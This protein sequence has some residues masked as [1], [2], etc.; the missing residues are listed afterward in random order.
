M[1]SIDFGN[2]RKSLCEHATV[3][4]VDRLE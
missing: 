2:C 1:G 3:E 4:D